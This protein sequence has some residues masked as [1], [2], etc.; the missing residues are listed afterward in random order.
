MPLNMFWYIL[1]NK[2]TSFISAL[3]APIKLMIQQTM[4]KMM[5]IG[6]KIQPIK[7]IKVKMKAT[8]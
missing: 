3:A 8:K 6:P 7:G 5:K 4:M 2:G 1:P